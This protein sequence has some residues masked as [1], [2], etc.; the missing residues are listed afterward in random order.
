MD[1]IIYN[2]NTEMQKGNKNMVN[3]ASDRK[4]AGRGKLCP[5]L[6]IIDW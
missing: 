2:K 1:V 5:E 6:D 3:W 4:D